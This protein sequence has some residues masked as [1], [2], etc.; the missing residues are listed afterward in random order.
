MNLY[1]VA[2]LPREFSPIFWVIGIISIVIF[3]VAI[4]AAILIVNHSKKK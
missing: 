3:I 2:F 4:V 1:D